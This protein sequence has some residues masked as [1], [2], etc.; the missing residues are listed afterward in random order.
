VTF[1][2]Y[3]CKVKQSK[4]VATFWGQT[5]KKIII[6]MNVTIDNRPLFSLTVSEYKELQMNIIK[7]VSAESNLNVPITTA[8]PSRIKINGIR[9]LASYLDVSVPT[10][11]KLK[12]QKKFTF[13]ESGNKVYFFSDEVNAGLK[14]DS[15]LRGQK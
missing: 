4:E 1:T 11:Q 8:E 3:F 14:V 12:N 13:Y 5:S 2:C 6:N 10:A 7:K 9:G 15:K